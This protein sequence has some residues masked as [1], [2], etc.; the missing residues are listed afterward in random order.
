M[1]QLETLCMDIALDKRL[2]QQYN[3]VT[4]DKDYEFKRDVATAHLCDGKDSRSPVDGQCPPGFSKVVNR[5]GV[6][7]CVQAC[8]VGGKDLPRPDSEGRCPKGYVRGQSATDPNS[9]CCYSRGSKRGKEIVAGKVTPASPPG[10]SVAMSTPASVAVEGPAE[11]RGTDEQEALASE[12]QNLDMDDLED[13]ADTMDMDVDLLADEMAAM[14][15]QEKQKQKSGKR[16]QPCPGRLGGV[17]ADGSCPPGNV[18]V[19]SPTVPG[20]RCCK[21]G[22]GRF[23]APN[24]SGKCPPGYKRHT[25]SS[26]AQCC[27]KR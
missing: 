8:K 19:D 17:R 21:W 14:K 26:G 22:C 10:K 16:K 6:E 1:E 23:K 9:D 24:A 13:L 2:F 5:Y 12:R 27:K 7:C 18:A 25:T 20:E 4:Q 11:D 3:V 15:V